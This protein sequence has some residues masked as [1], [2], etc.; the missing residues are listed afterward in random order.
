MSTPWPSASHAYDEVAERYAAF[1][2]ER[3]R[4]DSPS[5]AMVGALAEQVRT[6]GGG[7]VLDAGCGPGHISAHL[8][9]LGVRALGVDLS[10]RMVTLARNTRPDLCFAVGALQNLPV[11]GGSVAGVVANY[12][13]IHTPQWQLPPVVAELARVLAVGGV[14]LVSFQALDTPGKTSEPF[15]HAVAPAYRYAP[16]HVCEVL[17]QVGVVETARLVIP[18]EQDPVRGFAQAYVLARRQGSRND[19]GGGEEG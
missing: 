17:A 15:D 10:R 3:Y 6:N 18:A 8:R 14:L 4:T 7:P 12:A 16:D 2:G 5:R 13:I 19:H 9:D 11:R 1:A